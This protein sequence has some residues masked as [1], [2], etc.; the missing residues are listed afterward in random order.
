MTKGLELDPDNKYNDNCIEASCYILVCLDTSLKYKYKKA[1]Q[2][3]QQVTIRSLLETGLAR[4]ALRK[5]DSRLTAS[6]R[7]TETKELLTCRN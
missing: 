2:V 3:S 5:L 6:Y 1:I 7:Q 4:A